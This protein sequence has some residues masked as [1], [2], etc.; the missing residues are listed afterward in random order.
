MESPDPGIDDGVM[1]KSGQSG[2]QRHS[3]LDYLSPSE[4]ETLH[5]DAVTAA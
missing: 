4:F 3:T 2:S 5:T 1:P